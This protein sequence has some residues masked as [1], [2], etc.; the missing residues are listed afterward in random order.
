MNRKMLAPEKD[1]RGY[2]GRGERFEVPSLP[3]AVKVE[4]IY[5]DL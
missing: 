3:Q 5:T 1:R 4:E 2:N